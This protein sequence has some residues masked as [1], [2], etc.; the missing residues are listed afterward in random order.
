MSIIHPMKEKQDFHI[1]SGA[2]P[3][4]TVLVEKCL[5]I[6]AHGYEHEIISFSWDD[7]F[8]FAKPQPLDRRILQRQRAMD[9]CNGQTSPDFNWIAVER[10]FDRARKIWL[11]IFRMQLD[12]LFVVYGEGYVFSRQYLPG[13][14]VSEVYVNFPDPWPKRRH[15]KHRHHSKRLCRLKW[16]G[17]SGRMER[18]RL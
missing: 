9:R 12:N 14:S 4:Q 10:D 15:A 1:P 8:I 6:P 11:K 5:Y 7:P 18:R 16:A 17:L 3:T 2:K 13:A